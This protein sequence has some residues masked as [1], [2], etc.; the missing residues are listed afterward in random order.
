MD[1]AMTTKRVPLSR[2]RKPLITEEMV[3]L[4]RR[5]RELLAKGQE[6]GDEYHAINKRLNITLLR[7]GFHEVSVL[8]SE[9]DHRMPGYMRNLCSGHDWPISVAQRRALMQAL[10]ERKPHP[11]RGLAKPSDI[12]C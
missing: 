6:D 10:D 9:L 2:P 4:F 5:G 1:L 3:E 8:D 11:T 12:G 7:K